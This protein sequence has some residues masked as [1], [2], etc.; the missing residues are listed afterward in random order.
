VTAPAN[1]GDR[2]IFR[3]DG[4]ITS[5]SRQTRKSLK[6]NPIHLKVSKPSSYTG[7]NSP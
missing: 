5:A 6:S 3:K 7:E 4:T 1:L 2:Y